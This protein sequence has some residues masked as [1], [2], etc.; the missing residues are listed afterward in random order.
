SSSVSIVSS[1]CAVLRSTSQATW[2]RQCSSRAARRSTSCPRA[3]GRRICRYRRKPPTLPR[4]QRSLLAFG[5]Y[6]AERALIPSAAAAAAPVAAADTA[7][8][9]DTAADCSRSSTLPQGAEVELDGVEGLGAHRGFACVRDDQAVAASV[10]AQHLERACLW[11]HQPDV[12]HAVLRVDRELERAIV[13]ARRGRE[14][15]CDPVGP[16]L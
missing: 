9:T 15:L 6:G 14:H 7:A 16:H 1:T 2:R 11:V 13:A 4:A 12:G 3:N 8:A 10:E 5:D